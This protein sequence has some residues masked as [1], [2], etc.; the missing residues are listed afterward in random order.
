MFGLLLI[1]QK[2]S[3]LCDFRE[4]CQCNL[5][6]EQSNLDIMKKEDE[7]QQDEE[8]ENKKQ[9]NELECCRTEDGLLFNGLL[10]DKT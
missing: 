5:S 7:V 3:E 6:I 10:E 9:Q 8:Y 4:Q 2:C 1:S